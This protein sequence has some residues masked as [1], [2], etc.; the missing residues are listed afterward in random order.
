[1]L[2]PLILMRIP[3]VTNFDIFFKRD[4]DVFFKKDD[5]NITVEY[6]M[7]RD[8]PTQSGVAYP[9]YYVWI[10]V[11]SEGKLKN[12]G[13]ARVAAIDKD[14]FEITDFLSQAEIKAAP[15]NIRRVFPAALISKIESQ[16]GLN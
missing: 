12:E 7:L 9:K 10:K 6:T 1:M 8:G 5:A 11:L 16:A 3:S 4:L 2:N 14:K 15:E 13:A